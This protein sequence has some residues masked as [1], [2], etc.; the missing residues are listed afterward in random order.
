MA[1]FTV[2]HRKTFPTGGLYVNIARLTTANATSATASLDFV[3]DLRTIES[4][5]W[6]RNM[7][8]AT[9]A[10]FTAVTWTNASTYPGHATFTISGISA[11]AGSKTFDVVL[12]G[13]V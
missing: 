4:V 11:T 10:T 8:T 7:V 13:K 3:S 2:T 12:W 5:E 9:A 1:L 6:G